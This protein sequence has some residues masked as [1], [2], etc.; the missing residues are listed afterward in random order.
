MKKKEMNVKTV[1]NVCKENENIDEEEIL[2]DKKR[3]VLVTW[4]RIWF[5]LER[6]A[7]N[8][9]ETKFYKPTIHYSA[10]FKHY[11]FRPAIPQP[12]LITIKFH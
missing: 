6:L 1:G 10:S 11:H 3:L 2:W 12:I 4:F 7:R 8:R 9:I 5:S